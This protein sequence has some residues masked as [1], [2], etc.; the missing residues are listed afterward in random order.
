MKKSTKWVLILMMTVPAIIMLTVFLMITDVTLK[1][2]PWWIIIGVL[3]FILVSPFT[4]LLT[5]RKLQNAALQKRRKWLLIFMGIFIVFLF[6]MSIICHIHGKSFWK[7]FFSNPGLI[8][9]YILIVVIFFYA[10]FRKEKEQ[11][12]MDSTESERLK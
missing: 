3:V 12:P 6:M 2:I 11:K 9:Q 5:Q 8:L 4:F 1:D 10:F 7:I